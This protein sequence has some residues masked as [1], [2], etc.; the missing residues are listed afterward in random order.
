[1]GSSIFETVLYALGGGIMG[2]LCGWVVQAIISKRRIDQVTSAARTKLDGVTVERD[3]FADKYSRSQTKIES[4]RAA[5]AKRGTEFEAVVKKSKLLARNVLM[6]RTERENTKTKLGTMQNALGSLRQQ[7]T[8]LQSEFE[9]A[10]EFYKRELLK[11]LE[12][13]KLLE[14]E[15][16]AA[17]SEQESFA[18]LVESSTLE[19][20]STQNMIVAAQLRLGQLQVL[21]RNVNKLETENAQLNRDLVQIKQEFAARERD[22]AELEELRIHNK[23]L[24]R[25]VE[26]LEGSRKEHQTDAERY[27]Q[28]ADESEKLSDTLRLKLDD[29]EKNFLDIEKQQDQA[30]KDARKAAVVPILKNQG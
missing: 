16:D 1:M 18:K 19:H 11:S 3:Y 23:Q 5:I 7:T 26:S 10:Q 20:G 21:E 14:K 4:L 15:V 27:R 8:A 22:L 25:C 6:L 30:L 17:R 13:R 24:V 12:K 2:G 29:L 9:K 28:Q